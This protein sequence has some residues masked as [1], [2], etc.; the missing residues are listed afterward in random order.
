ME[1]Q[2]S[3]I[4]TQIIKSTAKLFLAHGC[5]R[6]TMDDIASELHISKRTLYTHFANKEE[7]LEAFLEYMTVTMEEKKKEVVDNNESPV[8]LMLSL[9]LFWGKYN[10]ELNL[11]LNDMKSL[12]PD[13]YRKYFESKSALRTGEIKAALRIAA[14]RG[15]LRKDVDIDR[16]VAVLHHF[17]SK[18]TSHEMTTETLGMIGEGGYTFLRGLLSVPAIERLDSQ[19][20]KSKIQIQ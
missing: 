12:Y 10:H 19:D 20:I 17:F 11:T 16:S 1:T 3:H 18:V 6:I 5:K 8:S 9:F 4:R 14:E 7:L 15:E 13:L 2:D